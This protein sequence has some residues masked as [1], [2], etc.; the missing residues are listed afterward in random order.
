MSTA[1]EKIRAARDL[2]LAARGDGDAARSSFEWPDITGEFNWAIDWFDAIARD[3]GDL[4]LW[5]RDEHG[6]DER[7]T[8][9]ELV[10]RSDRLAGW[11]EGQ[12]V[13]KGD[14][15]M[16]MLGNQVELWDAMLAAMKLG[17][18][19]LPTAQAL[20]DFDLED[21]IPRAQ[22]RVVVANPED[23]HKFDG[24]EGLVFV[25][26]GPPHDRWLSLRDASTVAAEPRRVV[27]DVDDPV[28]YYVTSGTTKDPK[29]VVHTP[30]SY[31]VGHLSTMYFI[32]V[33]P[34]D[35][36]LNISSPG[37]AKHAWSSFFSPWLAEATV[38][39][40]NYQ[41]FDAAV[42][43]KELHD[44]KVTTFC[45]PPT[46]WRMLIQAD[47]GEKPPGLREL[48]GAGEPLN[49]EVISTVERAWRLTI[50]DGYGQ[51]E[52]TCTVGNAPGERVKPGSM[53][54][55]MPGVGVQIIDPDT[56]EEADSG[57]IT[58]PLAPW[59]YN[60][61]SGY[62]G[63]APTAQ[64]DGRYHSGDLVT[65]DAE[66]FIT[67]VGRTDDVFKAS[68]YKIS[69]FELES[70]LIEHPAVVEC[71]I[72]PA[73]DP[74][75]AAVPKAYVTLAAGY[76]P[77]AETALSIL[78]HGRDRLAPYL[79]VRR[80]EFA[81]LPKTISGKVRRVVLRAREHDSSV[82]IDDFRYEQFPELRAH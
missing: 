57:E 73:P 65:R 31:P 36:H 61:M 16:L 69:P 43:L 38:F 72:V 47:L 29:L 64:A 2:L 53:G 45:A 54:K 71:A 56:G 39:S 9:G 26:T 68:D 44:S 55:L 11:L 25:T 70:V 28:L 59:P 76:E 4:A 12:G 1:T 23:E 30:L 75:R 77:S 15:I 17:A 19:I 41:R 13:G 81:D 37:W 20:Q 46:V 3:R 8:Y 22:V 82:E 14:A 7:Y 6:A 49:P 62:I 48:L 5:I 80:V 21:R 60:L 51:T 24:V 10:E 74:I 79:R 35:V 66:G 50:R 52:T 34:G 67:Y 18:I 27:T 32:G 63:G 40:F 78:T 42:M 58:L 33:R